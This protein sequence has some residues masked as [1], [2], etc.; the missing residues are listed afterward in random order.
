MLFIFEHSILSFLQKNIVLPTNIQIYTNMNTTA[1]TSMKISYSH[2]C[3]PI[4]I[5][6]FQTMTP[7][8]V[9][10]QRMIPTST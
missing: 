5:R 10:V 2:L 4:Y 7:I 6:S 1:S 3:I 9:L 8:S